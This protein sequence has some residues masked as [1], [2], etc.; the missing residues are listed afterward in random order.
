[1]GDGRGNE[2]IG[3][4]SVHHLFHNEHNRQIEEIKHTIVETGD[5]A[6][7]NEWLAVDVAAIP[8]TQAGIDALIWDGERLFQAGRF[9]TEMVYQHLV[10]EVRARRCPQH[11]RVP[12]LQHG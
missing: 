5:L 4:T 11:R 9:S 1:V 12:V 7:L 3:L 2:N 10:F 8:A 6:F